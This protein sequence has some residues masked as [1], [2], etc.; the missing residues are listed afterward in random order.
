MTMPVTLSLADWFEYH[1]HTHDQAFAEH[2][3]NESRFSLA[4]GPRAVAPAPPD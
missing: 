3:R 2:L 1:I 4:P